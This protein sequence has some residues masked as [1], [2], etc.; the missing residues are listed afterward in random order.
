MKQ[1][2]PLASCDVPMNRDES[3]IAKPVFR[4]LR[5]Q[6]DAS[7]RLAGSF[8]PIVSDRCERRRL[9]DA[10]GGHITRFKV[11]GSTKR[12]F[13]LGVRHSAG[14]ETRWNLDSRRVRTPVRSLLEG[15]V[16]QAYFVSEE[17]RCWRERRA[18]SVRSPCVSNAESATSASSSTQ[19]VEVQSEVK[20][21]GL[22]RFT[23]R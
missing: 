13:L 4:V 20:Y 19:R 5:D 23:V 6:N 17:V 10:E 16:M 3:T 7:V 18:T 15:G 11:S 14:W 1:A 9:V 8:V 12:G 22:C 2:T 21:N